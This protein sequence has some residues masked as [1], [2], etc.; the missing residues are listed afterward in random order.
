MDENE[1]YT[2]KPVRLNWAD[3]FMSVATFAKGVAEAAH[4]AWE[5][6]EISFAGHSNYIAEKQEFQ[7]D[8]GRA[9]EALT[10]ESGD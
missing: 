2:I 5:V 7:R 8:A 3:V 1:T 10:K 9:I 4:D 6:L